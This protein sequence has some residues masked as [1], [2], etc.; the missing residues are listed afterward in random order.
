MN[1]QSFKKELDS[2]YSDITDD[3]FVN[4][5]CL[6]LELRG[7][8]DVAHRLYAAYHGLEANAVYREESGLLRIKPTLREAP[9]DEG[10]QQ[11]FYPQWDAGTDSSGDVSGMEETDLDDVH[12]STDT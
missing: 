9:D 7:K 1:E 3:E 5:M 11:T 4:G 8:S 10:G 12:R 2:N 6:I